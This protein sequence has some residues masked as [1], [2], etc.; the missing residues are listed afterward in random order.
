MGVQ[1][2]FSQFRDGSGRIVKIERDCA[3]HLDGQDSEIFL[4]QSRSFKSSGLVLVVYWQL[5]TAS[6]LC[7]NASAPSIMRKEGE[8]ILSSRG[9]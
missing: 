6:R 3:C 1:D 9:S 8:A 7:P 4:G 5:G 2:D